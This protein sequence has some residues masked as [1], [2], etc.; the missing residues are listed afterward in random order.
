M[1][2]TVRRT[3]L[4]LMLVAVASAAA[5]QDW[6]QWRGPNRDGTVATFPN[7]AAWPQTL[8]SAWKVKVGIGHSSPVAVG[9]SVYVFSRE[10]DEEVLSS[11]DLGSGKRLWRQAYPAPYTMNPAAASHG[12]GPKSTPVVAGGRVYTLGISGIL[13]GFDA[14]TGKLVWRKDFSSQHKQTSPLYGSAMSPAVDAGLLIAHVGGHDDGA[15]TAFDAATGAPRWVW[16]GDGPGYASP[17][18]AEISGQRQVVTQTQSHVVGLSADKGELLWKVPFKTEYDQNSVTPVVH[19][20][21]VVYSG[22]DTGTHAVRV[23]KKGAAW[24][25]EPLWDTNDVSMYLSSP[26]LDGD[27]I[28]GFSHKKKGQF[29]ALDARTG[30][31]LW[32]SEGRQGDNAAVVAAGPV[33]FLL[34]SDGNLTVARKDAKAWSPLRT[35]TVADSPTW[36]HPVVTSQ[37]ILVKDAESLAFWRLE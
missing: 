18:I 2:M 15:L 29:F 22:L 5:A 34:T 23:V 36:A 25:T 19:G 4:G 1:F 6:P 37:G 35:Y 31:V 14:A 9:Q 3:A 27:R 26:V 12:K 8:P 7:R 21:T 24:V 11:F 16:K 20:D 30:Q 32:L 28:Y 10:G 13:S 17:L 33:L